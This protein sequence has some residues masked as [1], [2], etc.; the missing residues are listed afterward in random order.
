[1]MDIAK[2]CSCK[3]VTNNIEKNE[4][5]KLENI[6]VETIVNSSLGDGNSFMRLA[7]GMKQLISLRKQVLRL[8]TKRLFLLYLDSIILPLYFVQK[9]R[10]LDCNLIATLHW[11]PNKSIKAKMLKKLTDN[12][13]KL[14]VHTDDI[15]VKLEGLG[16]GNVEKIDYPMT[17]ISNISKEEAIRMLDIKFDNY[18]KTILYFGGTRIDKGI[19]ILLEAIKKCRS[20]FNII[21][22][23]QEKDFKRDF[24]ISQLQ[25]VPSIE[26]RL[27]L[28][29]INDEDVEAYFKVCDIVVL[30]YRKMFQGESGILTEAIN[31]RNA[32][33]VP[34]IMHFPSIVDKYN[35]GQVYE[36][37]NSEDLAK[38]IDFV[39]E[40]A[41]IYNE[42]REIA[43]KDNI[44]KRSTEVFSR[45][46]K[47]LVLDT[48]V[49]EL[50]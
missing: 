38:K 45:V 17:E 16:I 18:Y 7:N 43:F 14:V 12:G 29:Y 10:P 21:I 8:D 30:P 36:A 39:V 40:N 26:F 42:G 44:R 1:M 20:K 41:D 48:D 15:K 3:Y 28:T 6:G 34:D 37:E 25:Q 50:V 46:Y 31:N 2:E 5:E 9:I 27:D 19:D 24:I 32:I 22:A 33:I 35:N 13:L 11:M 47:Q 49:E 23:G 4:I